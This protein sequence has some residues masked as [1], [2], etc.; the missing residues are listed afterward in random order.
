MKT[1]FSDPRRATLMVLLIAGCSVDGKGIGADFVSGVGGEQAGGA[2]GDVVGLVSG[3]GGRGGMAGM[4]MVSIDGKGGIV[5]MTGGTGGSAVDVR[6]DP[7]MA[8][9][10][11]R[12]GPAAAV[13]VG[14]MDAPGTPD[15]PLV[16]TPMGASCTASSTCASGFC[17][18]GV[19]C[20]TACQGDCMG[21]A[22]IRTNQSNGRCRPVKADTDPQNDCAAESPGTCKTTG[23]CNGQGSCALHPAGTTCGM[24]T[25]SMG[26]LTPAASCDGSGVCQPAAARPCPGGTPCAT[27]TTCRVRCMGPSDCGVSLYCDLSDGA[28]KPK[29]IAGAACTMASGGADCSTGNCVDGVC[30]EIACQGSCMACAQIKTGK[31][32]GKCAPVLADTDP[33]AECNE[34]DVSTC[35]TDGKCDGVSACRKFPDDTPCGSRCCTLNG[36]SNRCGLACLAGKCDKKGFE[37]VERCFDGAPCSSD[38]CTESGTTSVCHHEITCGGSNACCC[39]VG[40]GGSCGNRSSCTQQGGVCIVPS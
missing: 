12:D 19:C 35:G 38:S 36:L 23:V 11:R 37:S 2:G 18:D 20:E 1:S 10:P 40:N 39:K 13:D 16:T 34:Q 33:D 26:T 3:R 15:A 17:V 9:I 14:R 22:T 29:K 31:D 7:P 30:C 24:S 4:M 27:T 25:C 21:C 6:P 28:C 8:D 5:S 32:N